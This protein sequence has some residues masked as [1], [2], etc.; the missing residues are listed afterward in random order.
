[1]FVITE[2]ETYKYWQRAL[3]Q[4]KCGLGDCV[5]RAIKCTTCKRWSY[6]APLTLIS[7]T[8]DYYLVRC[9]GCATYRE[10]DKCVA[11]VLGFP[12][13]LS[14]PTETTVP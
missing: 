12:K 4:A 6:E 7:I 10:W 1:M 2:P 13:D 11:E 14:R 3:E 5:E 9:S 8:P